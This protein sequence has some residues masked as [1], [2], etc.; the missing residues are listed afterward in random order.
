MAL[1]LYDS[2]KTRHPIAD[3]IFSLYRHH[4]LLRE[5][6]TRNI[7]TRYKRSVMGVAWTMLNPLLTMLVLYVVFSQLFAFS[8]PQY[9]VYLLSGLVLWNF[10]AQSTVAAMRDLVW[11]GGLLQRIFIPRALFAV[12]AIGTGLV[13]LLLAL[14][15]LVIIMLVTG[16]QLSPAILFLPVSLTIACMFALGVGLGLSALAVF[17][18]DIVDMYQILLLA[19]MYLTPIF[20][21]IDI[22]AP[23][24]TWLIT[25]NPMY[26]ILEC[27]RAPIY[28]GILPDGNIFIKA[29]IAATVSMLLGSWLFARKSDE[30]S[31]YL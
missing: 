8:L 29:I 7:K 3:E 10:F 26:Y 25:A 16:A 12:A 13:N 15:P 4:H 14:V 21:P 2:E 23:K 17:F 11:S 6:I 19:W 27:F 9:L 24:Y 22:L 18:A 20:Y 28:L 30:F 31:Y 5:L 1:P